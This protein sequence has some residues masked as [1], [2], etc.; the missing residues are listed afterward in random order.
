MEREYRYI[1]KSPTDLDGGR[2]IGPGEYTGP[3]M[4]DEEHPKNQQLFDEGQL[5]PLESE[6]EIAARKQKETAEQEQEARLTGDAL[7][8]RAKE[9]SIEGR[10]AM[11]A[12]EL[13]DAIA[14]AEK[15]GDGS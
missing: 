2:P 3:I 8:A 5:I 6:S 1:G 11:T 12:D 9:L 7:D 10:S 15:D 13:R 4:V 14:A